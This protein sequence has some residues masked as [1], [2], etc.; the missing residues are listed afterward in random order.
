MTVGITN[1]ELNALVMT[2][3]SKQPHI[4]DRFVEIHLGDVRA[5]SADHKIAMREAIQQARYRIELLSAD[6][7]TLEYAF[8]VEDEIKKSKG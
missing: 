2:F 4:G 6:L 7:D 8:S 1:M 3:G 5:I